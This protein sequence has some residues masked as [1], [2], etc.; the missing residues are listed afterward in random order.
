MAAARPVETF[1]APR[2]SEDATRLIPWLREQNPLFR[3][4]DVELMNSLFVGAKLKKW[5][6]G[7][8]I[9]PPNKRA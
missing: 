4:M 2:R 8:I 1:A 7:S 3:K 9:L 5:S 6:R